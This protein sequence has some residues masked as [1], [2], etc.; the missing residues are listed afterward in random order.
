MLSGCALTL[1]AATGWGGF[2]GILA[3][4]FCF[5][6]SIGLV[7]ANSVAAGL[8]LFSEQAGTAAALMGT[9]QFGV[10]AAL[11]ALVGI[12]D[13]GSALPMGGVMGA[14]GVAGFA[15]LELLARHGPVRPTRP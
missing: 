10:G 3:P 12:L 13:D 9:L 4:L 1:A 7:A 8:D 15:A 6:A 14:A 2:V 5:V 11:S